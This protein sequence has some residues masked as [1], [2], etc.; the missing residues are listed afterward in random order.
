MSGERIQIRE[1]A[2]W[3]LDDCQYRPVSFEPDTFGR[4]RQSHARRLVAQ[5]SPFPSPPRV[6]DFLDD[7]LIL[8]YD[9]PPLI[10]TLRV[11]MEETLSPP[12][13]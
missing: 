7:A 12:A 4:C 8:E 9:R 11:T 3:D 5:R 2:G 10:K 13:P 6:T 1:L